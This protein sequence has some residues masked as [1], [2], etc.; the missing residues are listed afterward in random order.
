MYALNEVGLTGLVEAFMSASELEEVEEEEE[1]RE[2]AV[3]VFCRLGRMTFDRSRTSEILDVAC[4]RVMR[5]GCT[6]SFGEMDREYRSK[7]S[8]AK[9][10]C[11]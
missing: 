1:E 10:F 8:A 3:E 9:L 11:S 2:V 5:V 4:S 6:A 7:E